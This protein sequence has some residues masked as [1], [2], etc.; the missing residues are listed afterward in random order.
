M[1]KQLL[2]VS[3]FLSVFLIS[4]V[5][6]EVLVSDAGVEYESEIIDAL[7]DSEWVE[8]IIE[9]QEKNDTLRDFVISNLSISEFQFKEKQLLESGFVGNISL[10]GL[11][12]LIDSS[13]VR[14]IY[15]NRIA[16]IL[17]NETIEDQIEEKNCEEDTDCTIVSLTCCGCGVASINTP[18]EDLLTS[19]NKDSVEQWNNDFEER[20]LGTA[21]VLGGSE[22][23]ANRCN[24]Y[25]SKCID[26]QC[27]IVKILE[28]NEETQI[29][30]KLN[31]SWL[32][33][34]IGVVAIIILFTVIKRNKN[35]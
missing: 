28:N 29:E 3:L 15:L 18:I 27:S 22:E 5:S 10:E 7:D 24:S 2:L 14:L 34:I 8:V 20:C 17:D 16:H 11:N 19:I 9:I 33:I 13:D 31:F 6:A 4:F 26:N 23:Q 35:Q 32:Y 21:C 12:K 30:E 1:K 25:A